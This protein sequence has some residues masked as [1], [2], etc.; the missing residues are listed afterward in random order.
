MTVESV[1]AAKAHTAENIAATALQKNKPRTT[2]ARL[3]DKLRS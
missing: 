2:C 3:L 1:L